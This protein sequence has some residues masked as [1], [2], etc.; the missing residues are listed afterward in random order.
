MVETVIAGALLSISARRCCLMFVCLDFG[1]FVNQIKDPDLP[2]V[3]RV[4]D[5]RLMNTWSST[6]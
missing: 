4:S 3:T 1:L 2:W 6:A 5:S